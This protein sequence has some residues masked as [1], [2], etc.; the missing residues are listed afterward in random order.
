MSVVD[1]S[2]TYTKGN[3]ALDNAH[4]HQVSAAVQ[5]RLPKRTM[6]YVAAIHQRANRSHIAKIVH[7]VYSCT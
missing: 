1:A 4:A 5:Y 3:G 6:L 2:Y 7:D